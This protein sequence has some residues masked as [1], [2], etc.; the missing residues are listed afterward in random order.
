[1]EVGK[2][3]EA[4]NRAKWKNKNDEEKLGKG[5]KFNSMF[6]LEQISVGYVYVR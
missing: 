6:F 3:W 5:T 4:R 1:M 2:I